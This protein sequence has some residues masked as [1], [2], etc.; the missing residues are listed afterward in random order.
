[1]GYFFTKVPITATITDHT[2]AVVAHWAKTD[3]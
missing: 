1:M 2:K 3:I